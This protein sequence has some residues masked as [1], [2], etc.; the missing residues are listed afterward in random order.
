MSDQQNEKPEILVI[1]DSKVIRK[2]AAKMLASDYTVHEA[3]DGLEGWEFLQNNT[4]VS[5]VFTDI[6]M[7]ELNGLELLARIREADDEHIS[8]LPVIMIT[9]RED[10]EDTKKEVFEAGA[11]DFITKPFSSIDLI[12][13]A[14]S[15]A[16]LNRKVTELEQQTGHDKLTGLFN[17][18]S[19]E[20]Q[21]EKALSFAIRHGLNI[22]TVYLEIVG[23][24]SLFLKHGKTVAQQIV[25]A[26]SKRLTGLLRTEDVAARIGVA[27]FGL[28][29]PLTNSTHTKI[30][31]DRLR[32]SIN[33]LVFDTGSEKIRIEVAAGMTSPIAGEDMKYSELMEHA[34]I[35][36][37][38]GM[39]KA[40][41]K[42]ASYAE[43]EVEEQVVELQPTATEEDLQAAFQCI[44]DGEYFKIERA[45][46]NALMDR[47]T[48]FLHFVENQVDK[49]RAASQH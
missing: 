5:V 49:E 9:G 13:R 39:E 17:A 27:K 28:L 43:E 14:K 16:Q 36:L 10:T 21:G 1:D 12:T 25:I 40:G 45:H 33:K 26:V 46:L 48:P 29:L 3:A 22:S 41:D 2:A 8:A 23:F 44:L 34:G 11:T 32:E 31:V 47:L 30:A 19:L 15:Y 18:N 24:Q 6:Q 35:A 37:A 42:I 7:P 20:E 38:R 4:G